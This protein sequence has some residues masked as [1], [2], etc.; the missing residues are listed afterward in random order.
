MFENKSVSE[1]ICVYICVF[2]CMCEEICECEGECVCNGMHVFMHAE[3]VC[4]CMCVS[5]HIGR[6]CCVFK[7]VY[8]C[9]HACLCPLLLLLSPQAKPN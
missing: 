1:N 2:N 6:E 4:E 5:S 9:V 8:V 7:D 3:G